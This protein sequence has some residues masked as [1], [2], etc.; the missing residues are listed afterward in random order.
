MARVKIDARKWIVSKLLPKKYGDRPDEVHVSTTVTNLV[1]HSTQQQE[2]WQARHKA[3]L[4]HGKTHGQNGRN[5]ARQNA[6]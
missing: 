3:A 5:D 1:Q 4:E 2:D 6:D